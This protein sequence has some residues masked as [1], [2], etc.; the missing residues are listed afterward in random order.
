MTAPPDTV[1]Y[2]GGCALCHH[3]VRF[4]LARDRDGSRFRFAPIGGARFRSELTE[5]ERAGL[6]DAISV[7]T[8]DG[9]LLLRSTAALR[10]ASR[11]GGL[12]A[13]LARV[14]AWVPV[15]LRD[16]VYDAIARTRYQV[17]GRRSDVCPVIAPELRARFDLRP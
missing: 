12:H 16:V 15:G 9:R 13:A 3:S 5:A 8:P 7:R 17:F 4:L 14:F 6:P 11:L 10:L 2:D 1:F